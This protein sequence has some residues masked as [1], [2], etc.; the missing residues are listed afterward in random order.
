MTDRRFDNL[1]NSNYEQ[2][3]QVVKDPSETLDVPN[4]GEGVTKWHNSDWNKYNGFYRKYPEIKS[5]VDKVAIWTAGKG[6]IATKKDM[7]RLEKIRGWGKD[8]FNSIMQNMVRVKKI[9]GDS[10]A[11]IVKDGAGRLIN[12][13]PMNPGSMQI[14]TNQQGM[15]LRYE[16]IGGVNNDQIINTWEPEEI[17]HLCNDRE[18]DE[19]HGI[20]IFESLMRNLKNVR[21]LDEDM[22][23]V[24][25]RYVM[26]T[27]LWKADTD[28]DG[29]L[30]K[31][32]TKAEKMRNSGEDIFMTKD[33]VEAD[34]LSI[35]QFSTVDPLTWRQ[36]WIQ[37]GVKSTGIPEIVMGRSVDVGT[38]ASARMVY[39]SFQQVIENEQLFLEEQI[40]LQLGITL[41]Y[42]FPARIDAA[43]EEDERKDGPI[44]GEKQS[45]VTI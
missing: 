37:E 12:L 19:I 40:K 25:H 8:S 17:F 1:T 18:A 36:E 35:P 3:I 14:V 20:S 6:F 44:E 13:K 27:L 26:P 45:D 34:T 22:R 23:K 15:L 41:N 10:Y 7:K 43:E 11:E 39:L 5:A 4:E 38:E 2:Q 9:N 32:K 29:E 21:Q 28:D 31:L 16:Q 24:F 33:A 30:A 42:E